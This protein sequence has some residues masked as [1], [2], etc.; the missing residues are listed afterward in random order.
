MPISYVPKLLLIWVGNYIGTWIVAQ[1]I[2]FTRNGDALCEAA[3][4][5]IEVKVNDGF[6][7]LFI[8]GIFCNILIYIAVSGYKNIPHELGKY[9]AIFFGVLVFILSGFEHC[10][11]D[12]FYFNMAENWTGDGF[13]R[14]IVITAGNATGSVIFPLADKIKAR[15]Q[16]N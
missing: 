8:L 9:L 13:L 10:V 7:S 4:A 5:L 14:L 15:K 16:E 3:K 2:R 1:V 6:L 11:A 12:M